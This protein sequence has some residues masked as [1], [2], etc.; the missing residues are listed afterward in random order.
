MNLFQKYFFIIL[1]Y[2]LMVVIS[3]RYYCAV[4]DTLWTKIYDGEGQETFYNVKQTSDSGF[5][6][7]GQTLSTTTYKS[8]LWLVKVDKNGETQWERK[9]AP[10]ESNVWG[11]DVIQDSTFYYSVGNYDSGSVSSHRKIY[12]LKMDE[13]GNIIWDRKLLYN[14]NNPN[15]HNLGD[16]GSKLIKTFGGNII[17][18]GTTSYVDTS[19]T[20]FD[21]DI[22]LIKINTNGDTLWSRR[23]DLGYLHAEYPRSIIQDSDS[24]YVIV[25]SV[26]TPF[27]SPW[28]DMFVAKVD[29]N[30]NMLWHRVYGGDGCDIATDIVQANDGGFAIVGRYNENYSSGTNHQLWLLKID[31]KGDSLWAKTYGGAD[32]DIGNSIA[33]THDGGFIMTGSYSHGYDSWYY[34]DV[35]VVRTDSIGDTLWTKTFGSNFSDVGYSIKRTYDNGYIICGKYGA[36]GYLIRLVPEKPVSVEDDKEKIVN[37]N[38]ELKQNYPNP[39]NP[40]TVIQYQIPESGFVTLKVYDILGNEV[41]TLINRKQKAGSYNINFNASALSSGIYFYQL[42]TGKYVDTKKMILLR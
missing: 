32:Y 15:I 20:L 42:K 40:S 26:F 18:L 35:F 19:K 6:C 12:I 4:P 7:I 21:D 41:A 33:L 25:G 17:V 22:L 24:G 28:D 29:K 16:R 39:F 11:A 23:Y 38:F 34:E 14:Y 36:D 31:S 9:V 37:H 8:F 2:F 27:N 5:I 13:S 3:V 1:M 30:G 10:K